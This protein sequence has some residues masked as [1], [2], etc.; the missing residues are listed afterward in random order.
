MTK[1]IILIIILEE[2][3]GTLILN[4]LFLEIEQHDNGKEKEHKSQ[5][6]FAFKIGDKEN[7]TN[8]KLLCVCAAKNN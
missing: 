2:H 3:G 4:L 6:L 7:H 5:T 8:F 1:I